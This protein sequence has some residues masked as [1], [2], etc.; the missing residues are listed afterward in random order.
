MFGATLNHEAR[1]YVS[2][3]E[4]SGIQ[5]AT[6]SSANGVAIGNLVGLESGVSYLDG[7]FQG[8]FS[9]NRLMVYDDPIWDYTGTNPASGSIHH[10]DIKYGFEG[11]YLSSYSIN[12]AVGS[13]PKV[14]ASFDVYGLISSGISACGDVAHP[15]ID[16]PTQGSISINCDHISTN[17]VIGFDYSATIKRNP[18]YV[19]GAS[20]LAA[21]NDVDTIYPIQYN[22]QIQIEI[23]DAEI[24]GSQAL[25]ILSLDT[26]TLTIKGRNGNLLGTY[27]IPNATLVGESISATSNGVMVMNLN[28]KGHGV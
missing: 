25:P 13:L 6:L 26:A 3:Q 19:F 11:A 9:L 21:A 8:Q 20:N 7:P 17:R 4:L 1:V 10:G 2:Q 23:D 27:D 15:I 12:A 14:N 28:Y 22:A 16:I 5:S 18:I 24:S